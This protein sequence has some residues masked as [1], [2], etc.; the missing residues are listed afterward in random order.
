MVRAHCPNVAA[1]RNEVP[2][3]ARGAQHRREAGGEGWV[4]RC[5]R[6]RASS[7]PCEGE[8]WVQPM[9]AKQ[10]RSL[11]AGAPSCSELRPVLKDL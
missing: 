6:L 4:S 5:G 2:N 9:V 10:S 8:D 3:H 1:A 11:V 7:L